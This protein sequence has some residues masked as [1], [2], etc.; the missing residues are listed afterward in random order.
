[1]FN[2][3]N[4]V[5]FTG[6]VGGVD[7]RYLPDGTR[8]LEIRVAIHSRVK[9]DDKWEDYTNW[10]TVSKFGGPDK[11]TDYVKPGTRVAVTGRLQQDR[12]E[13]EDGQK[14]SQVKIRAFNIEVIEKTKNGN[15]IEEKGS[16]DVPF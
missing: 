8:I 11:L 10:L 6:R 15:G 1:M 4:Q 7:E 3:L 14:R 2:D 12:W 5:A 9:K 16:T 13:T